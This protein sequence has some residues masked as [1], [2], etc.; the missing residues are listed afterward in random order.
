MELTTHHRLQPT[1]RMARTIP[2]APICAYTGVLQGVLGLTKFIPH[3]TNEINI[4]KILPH[5]LIFLAFLL[6]RYFLTYIGPVYVYV[7]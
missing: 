7:G 1:F 6:Q 2:L 3:T 5:K 4:T